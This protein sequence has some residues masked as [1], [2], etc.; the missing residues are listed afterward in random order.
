MQPQHG[1]DLSN[2]SVTQFPAFNQVLSA[3]TVDSSRQCAATSTAGAGTA[4][5]SIVRPN[6]TL[7][8]IGDVGAVFCVLTVACTVCLLQGVEPRAMSAGQITD[9]RILLLRRDAMGL[10]QLHL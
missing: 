5:V 9:I 3:A 6:Q 10:F 8:Y 4:S 2:V 1:M 7:K